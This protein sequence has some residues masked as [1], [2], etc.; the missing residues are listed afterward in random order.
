MMY[1]IR[2]YAHSDSGIIPEWL[3]RFPLRSVS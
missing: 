3:F 1:A 2:H